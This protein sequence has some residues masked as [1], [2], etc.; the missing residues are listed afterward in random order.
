MSVSYIVESAPEAVVEVDVAVGDNFARETVLSVP[1]REEA[2][3][4]SACGCESL[5]AKDYTGISARAV[6]HGHKVVE[7]LGARSRERADEIDRDR[8]ATVVR[9]WEGVKWSNGVGRRGLV[10]LASVAVEEARALE[11]GAHAGPEEAFAGSFVRFP[12]AAVDKSVV[13]E[14][15]HV[16]EKGNDSWYDETITDVEVSVDTGLRYTG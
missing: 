2:V 3:T 10:T 12:K 1:V 7:L 9:H 8:L 14:L 6:Y 15:E 13:R 4:S 11:V 16:L 5:V